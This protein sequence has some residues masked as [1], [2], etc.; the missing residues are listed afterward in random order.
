MENKDN[1]FQTKKTVLLTP[2][3]NHHH[4]NH[5]TDKHPFEFSSWWMGGLK[6]SSTTIPSWATFFLISITFLCEFECSEVMKVGLAAG[7]YSGKSRPD[8]Y[9][10]PQALHRVFGPIG[11]SLHC[12]VFVTS[13]CEHF[14]VPSGRRVESLFLLPPERTEMF[15]LFP[16]LF[17]E[18]DTNVMEASLGFKVGR[19]GRLLRARFTGVKS[20]NP[21]WTELLVDLEQ[22]LS[23]TETEPPKK[24]L[25]PEVASPL[26]C[27]ESFSLGFSSYW[28]MTRGYSASILRQETVH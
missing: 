5:Q 9:R 20:L 12:G 23:R 6:L 19:W 3:K 18:H 10:T 22:L 21:K 28:D 7:L 17:S 24:M 2:T 26:L 8:R 16:F 15:F 25:L 13:Q 4:P 11:P 27:D 1:R 14:L